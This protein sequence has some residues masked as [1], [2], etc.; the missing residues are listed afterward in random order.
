[1]CGGTSISRAERSCGRERKGVGAVEQK[2]VL[3]KHNRPAC[4]QLLFR[5]VHLAELERKVGR[6]QLVIDFLQGALGK[7]EGGRAQTN[8][9]GET[10]SI[11]TS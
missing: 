4:R 3:R 7:A 5:S 10:G 1:M 2:A 11:P 6:Q 8:S 9:S